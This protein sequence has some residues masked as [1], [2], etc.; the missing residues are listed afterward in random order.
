MEQQTDSM[1]HQQLEPVGYL[2][3]RILLTDGP[4]WIGHEIKQ[5]DDAKA[6]IIDRT[7]ILC[8]SKGEY[9]T[10]MRLLQDPMEC[11]SFRDLMISFKHERDRK[12]LGKRIQKL[13]RKLPAYLMIGCEIGEGYILREKSLEE[14][15]SVQDSLSDF[16]V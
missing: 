8:R 10:L 11:V 1:A 12:A 16:S 9:Q 5:N 15:C 3:R 4:L 14:E 7:L 6:V 13:R 2:H